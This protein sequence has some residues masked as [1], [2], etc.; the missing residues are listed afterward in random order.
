MVNR[1]KFYTASEA[2]TKFGVDRRTISRW[3]ASG[4][5]KAVVTAGGH[6]RISRSEI[7]ALLDKNGFPKYTPMQKTILIVDDEA[8]VRRTLKQRLIREGF[9]VETAPDGFNA[10]LKAR[11][12]KP[13]L[14]IL[15]LIMD[16]IDGF[17][18]CRTIKENNI[19]KETKI[20]IMTG[21]DTPE[22]RERA[23]REGADGYLPKG[24]SFKSILSCIHDLLS[25]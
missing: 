13:K 8:P 15:D 2:A 20:L 7:D 10:G 19:L 6:L 21:F 25:T 16:G 12:I 5:I 18:V 17:E 23:L 4:K 11:D 3:V 1:D 14:I 24:G 22:N 9:T